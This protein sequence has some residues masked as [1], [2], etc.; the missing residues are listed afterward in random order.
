MAIRVPQ[1]GVKPTRQ[2]PLRAAG[3]GA[4]KTGSRDDGPV[5][6]SLVDKREVCAQVLKS[7][8]VQSF[9]DLFYL[10]HRVDTQIGPDGAD[11][12]LPIGVSP[13]QMSFLR[14]N[15]TTA[16][17]ARRQGDVIQV[18]ESYERLA[19]HFTAARDL[20]TG[21]FFYEKC[22]E[23]AR[24]ARNQDFEIGALENLGNAYYGL[25]E[26]EK[27]QDNHEL[28]VQL[29]R[30]MRPEAEKIRALHE[31]CKVYE[32]VAS[33]HE[34]AGAYDQAIHIHI[35]F[36]DC[37]RDAN[38]LPSV[39]LGQYRI[40]CCHNAMA[41]ATDALLYLK[42]YLVLC[43]N[44]GDVDGE[45]KAYA[46]LATTFEALGHTQQAMDY[47]K[48]Y[49]VVAEKIDNVV[50]QA[51]ACRR[52]G[53]LYSK[54]REFALALEMME[55]NFELIRNNSKR[56]TRL[57]D[58]ARTSLGVIRGH[59]QFSAFVDFVTS[60]VATFLKWKASRAMEPAT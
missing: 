19:A 10:V 18:F 40:G 15:L 17:T 33:I 6:C 31:L 48:E 28:H 1:V 54:T 24:I 57:L 4:E 47:L 55:R 16:E 36:L 53:L 43:K 29:V 7:G 45:C 9:V 8:L 34:R 22:L 14:D 23:I 2:Q 56:D 21:V 32:Q 13:A 44:L 50:A 52:L 41:Q 60:D 5:F 25:K 30:L 11:K 42:D 20:R 12:K 51:E 58:V 27:A 37:A 49:L 26:F 38:D 59:H 39:A 3:N 46:A 35:K